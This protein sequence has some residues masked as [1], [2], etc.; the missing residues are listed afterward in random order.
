MGG[1]VRSC[2]TCLARP[3]SKARERGA[4]AIGEFK[5][6]ARPSGRSSATRTLRGSGEIG[7][8]N[9]HGQILIE[10][11]KQ[12]SPNHPFAKVW[13][14]CCPT[15]GIYKANSCDFHIR[16]CPEEGGQPQ[17][18]VPISTC[19]PETSYPSERTTRR[20]CRMVHFSASLGLLFVAQRSS[21]K[22]C[23]SSF[24]FPESRRAERRAT[25][26]Q[27]PSGKCEYFSH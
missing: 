13:I 20:L 26:Y 21:L 5:R 22:R 25:P 14:V 16:R 9:R 3:G 24:S 7:K 17:P 6:I 2:C 18:L 27:S 19:W 11:T 8:H 4:L 1:A 10:A 12:P 23:G 15:H